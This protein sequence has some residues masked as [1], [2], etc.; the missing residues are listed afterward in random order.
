MAKRRAPTRKKPAARKAKA[1]QAAPKRRRKQGAAFLG[2]LE[3]MTIDEVRA[4]KPE[5]AVLPL[6]STEPHGP[7]LPYGTDTWQVTRLARLGVQRANERGA[8]AI[9]YPALPITNNANVR[10]FPFACR[11][12]VRTLIQ[13]IIDI[14]KQAWED[15]VRKLVLVNGHGGNPGAIFGALREISGMDDMPFVCEAGHLK[16]EGFVSPIEH[17]S[18]HAGESETSR[19]MW[20]R[21]DLVRTSK[22]RNN[23]ISEL[24]IPALAMANFVR[25][26]HL[27]IPQ[28]AG[29]ETRKA[30]PKKGKIVIEA[31]A[32]ALAEL[33]VQLTHAKLDATF[34]Y[35]L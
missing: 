29:G 24:R 17:P 8:R 3:E 20:I 7:H 6:G 21:P 25:P 15:G 11:M 10:A 9:L 5:V 18:D 33:L 1:A 2:L 26:W 34:P 35:K 14:A 12:G 23:P 31:E 13:V 28:S 30:S 19:M 32:G 16:P 27:Y 4:F 22:L